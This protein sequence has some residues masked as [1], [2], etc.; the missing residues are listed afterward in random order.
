MSAGFRE[1]VA[2]VRAVGLWWTSIGR[3]ASMGPLTLPPPPG[4]VE[5]LNRVQSCGAHDQRGLLRKEDLVLPEFLQL[6]AQGPNSQQ[7]E[8]QVESA[9]QPKGSASDSIV[10]SAL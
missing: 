7:P 10:H 5:L 4:L 2:I 3:S 9:A 8:P 1:A 6:P